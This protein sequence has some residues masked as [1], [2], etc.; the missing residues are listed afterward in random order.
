MPLPEP[1]E[2]LLAISGVAISVGDL[3]LPDCPL[4][5]ANAAFLKITGYTL[6]DVLNRN[7][8]FLQPAEGAGPVRERM[9]AFVDGAGRA[10]EQFVVP[11]QRKNGE[12]FLNLVYMSR[13]KREGQDALILASQFDLTCATDVSARTYAEALS[14]DVR[15][16]RDVLEP[17]R[18]EVATSFPILANTNSLIARTRL[19]E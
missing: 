14:R 16:L 4:V 3:R 1:I 15:G 9:R 11:N 10:D 8:R 7:C 12:A 6:D 18:W 13:L 2:R 19:D 5:M 17:S